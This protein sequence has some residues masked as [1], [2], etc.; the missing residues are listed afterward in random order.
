VTAP[1]LCRAHVVGD[2]HRV[3]C[4]REPDEPA[5]TKTVTVSPEPHESKKPSKPKRPTM[6]DGDWLVGKEVPTGTWKA[7][8]IRASCVTPV[9]RRGLPPI[10]LHDLRHGLTTLALKQAFIRR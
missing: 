2:R 1:R 3:G 5:P 4:G 9:R 6:D 7:S 8:N 10:R